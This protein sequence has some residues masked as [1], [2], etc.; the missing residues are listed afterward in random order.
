MS[1][2]ILLMLLPSS[3]NA[4]VF[5]INRLQ[6]RPSINGE[7]AFSQSVFVLFPN[8]FFVAEITELITP[9]EDN[10]FINFENIY[11]ETNI[12]RPFFPE[13]SWGRTLGWIGR[14]QAANKEKTILSFGTQFTISD[15]PGL[16]ESSK[17]CQWKSFIQIFFLKSIR[18]AGEFD[19]YHYYQF[20]FLTR[21]LEIRGVNAY[22]SFDDQRDFLYLMQ[23]LIYSISK[24][25]DIYF[26]HS[27]QNKE[28]F[29]HRSDGSQFGIGTRYNFSF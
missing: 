28:D 8:K 13:H 4:K 1:T 16:D 9:I 3:S 6:Y 29:Q 14:I 23:D 21:K 27:Y 24:T 20:P 15:I 25:W 18:D 19:I 26:R 11:H 22:Y 10:N 12:G 7:S 17:K 5:N 2:M